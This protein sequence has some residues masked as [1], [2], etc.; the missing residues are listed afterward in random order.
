MVGSTDVLT[1]LTFDPIVVEGSNTDPSPPILRVDDPPT[2]GSASLV[3]DVLRYTPDGSEDGVDA[4]TLEVCDSAG[5]DCSSIPVSVTV[6]GLKSKWFFTNVLQGGAASAEVIFGKGAGEEFFVGDFDGNGIDDLAK[7]ANDT[8]LFEILDLNGVASAANQ[9]LGYGKPGD[10]VF[11]GDWDGNGT[12]TFAVRRG[13]QFFVKNSLTPGPADVVIGYGKAGDEVFVG[14]WDADGDD[15]FAVRRGNVFF[16][17]NTVTSGNAD[18][19]FGYGKAADDVLVGDWDA[20]G[21]DTFAVR[22]GN[23]IF[24]RNDFATAPAEFSFGFGKASDELFP[25]D[26]NNDDLDTFAVRRIVK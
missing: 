23:V 16:A 15:T 25:G 5:V 8:N 24:V 20:S 17:R 21:S 4:F 13:N 19:V 10:E 2:K 18:E 9:T 14:D 26:W 1:S 22:R 3:G 6:D 7:R 11:V 12:D